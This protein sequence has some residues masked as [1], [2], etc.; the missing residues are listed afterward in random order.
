MKEY[1]L[2]KEDLKYLFP[3]HGVQRAG[4]KVTPGPFQ[5]SSVEQRVMLKYGSMRAMIKLRDSR[6]R[7]NRNHL[8]EDVRFGQLYSV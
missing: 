6:K 3:H 5:K 7:K 4:A 8:K 2:K 1:L